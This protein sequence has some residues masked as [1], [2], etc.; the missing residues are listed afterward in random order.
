MSGSHGMRPKGGASSSG[1]SAP[2]WRCGLV[3]FIQTVSHFLF[4]FLFLGGGAMATLSVR[5]AIDRGYVRGLAWLSVAALCVALFSERV[6]EAAECTSGCSSPN[7]ACNGPTDSSDDCTGKCQ[8]TGT[9][10]CSNLTKTVWTNAS[11]RATVSGGRTTHTVPV[12]CSTL[13]SC[14]GGVSYPDEQCGYIPFIGYYCGG[15]AVGACS[16]CGQTTG[17]VVSYDSCIDDGCGEE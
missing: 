4:P 1:S 8:S 11:V 9:P 3:N 5:E 6:G 15:T 17:N 14:N 16:F 10:P 13:Y 7:G 12:S 2:L